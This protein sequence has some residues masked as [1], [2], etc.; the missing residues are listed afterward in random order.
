[1]REGPTFWCGTWVELRIRCAPAVASAVFRS[2][3]EVP[4]PPREKGDQGCEVPAAGAAAVHVAAGAHM[5]FMAAGLPVLEPL[6][7]RQHIRAGLRI[8]ALLQE[9]R[10][11]F[12]DHGVLELLEPRGDQV[13]D[14]VR[15]L[16]GGAVQEGLQH[17]DAIAQLALLLRLPLVGEEVV[18]QVHTV[19]ERVPQHPQRAGS[20]D[21]RR[22]LGA[23]RELHQ[24]RRPGRATDLAAH[25]DV[26]DGVGHP[27]DV[28]VGQFPQRLIEQMLGALGEAPPPRHGH[29]RHRAR[30]QVGESRLDGVGRLGNGR[31]QIHRHEGGQPV[32]V[33][34]AALPVERPL[35]HL[36]EVVVEEEDPDIPVGHQRE[37][38]RVAVRV[39]VG[40][41]QRV[42][43][44][45][46]V[47]LLPD[48]RA[49][50]HPHGAGPLLG[51]RTRRLQMRV[52]PRRIG[53]IEVGQFEWLC[54]RCWPL[55]IRTEGRHV[56]PRLPDGAALPQ[57]S[58]P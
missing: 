35:E 45:V 1:M 19:G 26:L 50:Q 27:V 18:A 40:A 41:Q 32:E 8:E 38:I 23:G 33:L 42:I 30:P 6:G 39:G 25:L 21:G 58:A 44:G 53:R 20:G 43:V 7:V 16:L 28:D 13:V 47:L 31:G 34:L 11:E 48:A 55:P 56:E 49:L 29:M 5:P 15:G 4:S 37:R 10:G 52:Q 17:Q 2:A 12:G 24:S 22:H 46:E 36:Q 54:H 14:G 57:G 51:M 3:A 9:E